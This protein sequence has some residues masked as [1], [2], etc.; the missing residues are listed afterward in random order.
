LGNAV[1]R[2]VPSRSIAARG[3][4]FATILVTKTFAGCFGSEEARQVF[5]EIMPSFR[6]E[7][8]TYIAPSANALIYAYNTV[9]PP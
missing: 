2:V 4:V 7:D 5:C 1:G 6:G 3:R 9:G 8:G